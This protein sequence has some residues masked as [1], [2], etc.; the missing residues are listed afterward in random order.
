MGVIFFTLLAVALGCGVGSKAGKDKRRYERRRRQGTVPAGEDLLTQKDVPPVP[1][2]ALSDTFWNVPEESLERLEE[3]FSL[4]SPSGEE[5]FEA[6]RYEEAMTRE[7]EECREADLNASRQSGAE[8]NPAWREADRSGN[9]GFSL[10]EAVIAQT[11]L[12]RKYH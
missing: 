5:A 2:Q 11:V 1:A 9:S 8:A 4:E 6:G 3:E 12:E 10:R 7:D